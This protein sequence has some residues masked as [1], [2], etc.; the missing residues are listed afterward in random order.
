MYEDILGD[1]N[2][3]NRMMANDPSALVEWSRRMDGS[4]G[5]KSPEYGEMMERLEKGEGWEGTAS[6]TQDGEFGDS[7]GSD[8]ED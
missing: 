2:L 5:E 3:V 7:E 1:T 6:D 4:E 8:L